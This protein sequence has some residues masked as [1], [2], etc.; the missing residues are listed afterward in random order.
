MAVGAAGEGARQMRALPAHERSAILNRAAD[1]ADERAEELAGTIS[2]EV[3]K[4]IGEA[5]AEATR[6]GAIM[7]VSAWEGAHCVGEMLPLDATV[8]AEGKFGYTVRQPCGV[9]VA[10]TPFNYPALLLLHKVAPALAAGNAVIN[11]PARQTPLT[12][13]AIV[14]ILLE[15]GLPPMA[16]Q[17]LTGSGSELG[18][19]LCSD[20][21]VRKISFTG[22]SAVGESIAREAGLKRLSLELGSSCPTVVLG[23]ADVDAA[24]AAIAAGGYANAGQV[25]RSVQRVLV[26]RSAHG[27]L[28]DAL[29]PR[30]EALQTGDPAD[31]AT[32]LGTLISDEE[33]DR[34]S[35]AISAASERGADVLV[36]GSAQGA[37]VQAAVVDGVAPSDS[38]AREELFGPAV[39]VTKVDGVEEAIRVAND[40][41]YGLG[42]GVFT[43]DIGAA[44]RFVD[45]VD[46]GALHVNWTPLWRADPMPYGGLKASGF[47]KEG[48]RYAVQEMTE[49]KTVVLHGV[50]DQEASS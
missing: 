17:L 12:A 4:L 36:G 6:A 20:S 14:S 24:A 30:V 25:C 7:R 13:M 3:G 34:V 5:R 43:R 48:P 11:K 10:I 42:A 26:D 15:A 31:P 9:V 50:R 28:L 49:A 22:S 32:T 39:A 29:L 27:D 38:L 23:D 46:A 16:I 37:I 1:I 33:A 44:M 41:D 35:S 19:A 2:A 47:G 18:P 21:R 40:S 45:G 8:G